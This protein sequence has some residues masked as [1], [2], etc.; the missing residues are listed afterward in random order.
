MALGSWPNGLRPA[1][2]ILY[3]GKWRARLIA[4]RVRQSSELLGL[5]QCPVVFFHL[6]TVV[7]HFR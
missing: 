5:S 4:E 6:Q 2:R 1:V 7:S 3:L